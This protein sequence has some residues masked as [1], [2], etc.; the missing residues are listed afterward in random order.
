MTPL[1]LAFSNRYPFLSHQ[2]GSRLKK[3][4]T[5][6]YLP[7]HKQVLIRNISRVRFLSSGRTRKANLMGLSRI[8]TFMLPIILYRYLSGPASLIYR[9][10]SIFLSVLLGS[11]PVIT[12]THNTRMRGFAQSRRRR[13]KSLSIHLL[14]YFY[15]TI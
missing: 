12:N 4:I 8:F 6:L 1:C 3:G 5:G 14:D 11:T 2:E 9:A 7:P 13:G 10:I 15:A